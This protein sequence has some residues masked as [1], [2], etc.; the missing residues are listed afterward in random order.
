MHKKSTSYIFSLKLVILSMTAANSF[1]S[2]S[3]QECTLATG[4]FSVGGGNS[5]SYSVGQTAYTTNNGISGSVAQGIQQPY[6]ISVVNSLKK[7][8]KIDLQVSAYPNPTSGLLLLSINGSDDTGL[9]YQLLD[10]HGKLL[11]SKKISG[12][13]TEIDMSRRITAIYFIKVIQHNQA[14]KVFKIEKK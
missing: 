14:I 3:A 2:L 4:G 8:E 1:G 12:N 10:F 7:T 9:S 11:E 13:R 5:I 6:E